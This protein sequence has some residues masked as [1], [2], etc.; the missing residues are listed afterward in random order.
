[1]TEEKTTHADEPKKPTFKKIAR[2]VRGSCPQCRRPMTIYH[3]MNHCPSCGYI[4][5][6]NFTAK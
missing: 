2:G 6:S 4:F 3:G 1:M 5:K